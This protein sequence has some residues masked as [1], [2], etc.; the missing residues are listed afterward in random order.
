MATNEKFKR[1]FIKFFGGC[2]F[3][4]GFI[5][6]RALQIEVTLVMTIAFILGGIYSYFVLKDKKL[7]LW[8]EKTNRKKKNETI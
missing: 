7:I 4:G 6:P 3:V 8:K 2:I 1:N 5:D